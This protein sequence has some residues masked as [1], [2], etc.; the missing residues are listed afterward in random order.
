MA[1]GDNFWEANLLRSCSAWEINHQI[2]MPRAGT[3]IGRGASDDC[4]EVCFVGLVIRDYVWCFVIFVIFMGFGG[5]EVGDVVK[6][7][8]GGWQ[9]KPQEEGSILMGKEG[10]GSHYM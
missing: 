5:A 4:L 8:F 2:I 7:L 6:S 10:W 3:F 1:D 9:C